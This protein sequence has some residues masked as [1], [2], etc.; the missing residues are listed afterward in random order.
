MI[1]FCLLSL[2]LAQLCA[3][4]LIPPAHISAKAAS[5]AIPVWID[6]D[7]GVDDAFAIAVLLRSRKVDIRG[8]SAVAGNTTVENASNNILTLLDAAQRTNIPVIVGAAAPL[9]YPLSY[10]G[11]Y[12]HGADGFQG[13]Q[14]P[15]DL[16]VLPHDP[17]EAICTA[18]RTTPTLTLLAL[19]PATNVA[20]AAR[21]CQADLARIKIIALNGAKK[22][23]NRTPVAETNTH[24]DPQALAELLHS[25][26]RVT[27]VVLDATEPITFE[28]RKMLPMLSTSRDPLARLLA[29]PL[30]SYAGV[31]AIQSGGQSKTFTLPDLV[32]VFYLLDPSL[33]T[34]KH[35]LVTVGLEDNPWRGSTIIGVTP[36]EMVLM[37]GSDAELSDLAQRAAQGKVLDIPAAMGA[38]IMR[39]PA[40]ALVVL[41]L[42]Q[43]FNHRAALQ[44]S[45]SNN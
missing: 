26:L 15:H 35:A 44:K 28:T 18:A 9:T 1:R 39:Q 5:P 8:I 32:A 45:F 4:L 23:G 25:G 24:I 38:I 12:I 10:V 34:P 41:G 17:A 36:T 11:N 33:A 21:S 2:I 42:N 29:K 19:G 31:Q 14:R 22:G 13:A 16:S 20:L 37:I 27:L 40:N 30:G 43:K 3:S 7:T 6:S